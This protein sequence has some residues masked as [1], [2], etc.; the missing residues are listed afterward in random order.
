MLCKRI[1]NPRHVRFMINPV[2]HFLGTSFQV[3]EIIIN[4]YFSILEREYRKLLLLLHQI[5]RC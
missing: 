2:H 3:N 4:I 1:R 5:E